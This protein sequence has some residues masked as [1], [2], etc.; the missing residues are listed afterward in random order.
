M[1]QRPPERRP[2]L[3]GTAERRTRQEIRNGMSL[4][5]VYRKHEKL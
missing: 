1:F 2:A 5:D 4:V 3:P